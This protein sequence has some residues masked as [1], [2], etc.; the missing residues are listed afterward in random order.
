LHVCW[1]KK[2][3][4]AYHVFRKYRLKLFIGTKFSSFLDFRLILSITAQSIF[5][6]E[7]CWKGWKGILID[8]FTKKQEKQQQQFFVLIGVTENRITQKIYF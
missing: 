8:N 5:A 1:H 2:K 7:N 6:V 4:W 3:I